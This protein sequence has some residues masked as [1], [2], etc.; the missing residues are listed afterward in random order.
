M[1]TAAGSIARQPRHPC[2]KGILP[3]MQKKDKLPKKPM[4]GQSLDEVCGQPP[5]H[6]MAAAAALKQPAAPTNYH[7]FFSVRYAL[8]HWRRKAWLAARKLV[9]RPD[10]SEFGQHELKVVMYDALNKDGV[11]FVPFEKCPAFNPKSGCPGHPMHPSD[12]SGHRKEPVDSRG[13]A[14]P[15][16]GIGDP[17]H[18][19]IDNQSPLRQ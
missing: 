2:V 9:L 11:E 10:G 3:S 19:A 18:F 14:C 12:G 7:A 6:F 5:G 1:K 13:F 15:L 8:K 16:R 4:V 17:E